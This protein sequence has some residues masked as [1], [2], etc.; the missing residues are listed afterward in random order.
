[1]KNIDVLVIGGG[2][3]GTPAAMALASGGRR[4][5][6]VEKGGGQRP[7]FTGHGVPPSAGSL[8]RLWR[9]RQGNS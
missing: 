5:F 7:A 1:M 6:L 3:G 4:V 8:A 2:P 9:V